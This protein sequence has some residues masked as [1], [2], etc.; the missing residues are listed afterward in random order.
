MSASPDG[1]VDMASDGFL[2]IVDKMFLFCKDGL[3]CGSVYG[4]SITA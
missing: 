2:C 4:V 1:N 3:S